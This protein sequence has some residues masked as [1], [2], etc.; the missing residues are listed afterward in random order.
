GLKCT[1]GLIDL[2]GALPLCPALDS[3]GPLCRT[4]VDAALLLN[5]L[6]NRSH[7]TTI[8]YRA[9]EL[10][11]GY[12]ADDLRILVLD[13]AE[14]SVQVAP[15]IQ[16][17]F[18]NVQQVFSSCGAMLD[19]K[20]FP[21]DFGEIAQLSGEMMAASAWNIHAGYI[22]DDEMPFGYWV[23]KRII[24]GKSISSDRYAMLRNCH[25]QYCRAW[26][27]W[28]PRGS[29]LLLPALPM[30]ACRVDEADETSTKLGTFARAANFVGA[31][32]ITFPVGKTKTGLPVAMQLMS[33]PFEEAALLRTC[34]LF[35]AATDWHLRTPAYPDS[36]P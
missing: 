28:I 30:V 7:D 2:T 14:F 3:A 32:G 20:P 25:E 24:S 29:A 12:G 17:G 34:S 26:H 31:C 19:K 23:R 33:G 4:A 35:Q 5:V 11:P 6:A 15:E 18:R 1:T 13:E 16:E 21:F 27:N 36:R 10:P 22:E 8:S 9:S